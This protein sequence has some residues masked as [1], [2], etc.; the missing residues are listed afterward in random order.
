MI[1]ANRV[2]RMYFK[3][4]WRKHFRSPLSCF[5]P[6]SDYSTNTDN[7]RCEPYR[8]SVCRRHIVSSSVYMKADTTQEEIERE[9]QAALTRLGS[10]LSLTETCSKFITPSICLTA[11]PLCRETPE[12]SIHQLCRD[13]CQ[14]LETDVCAPLYDHVDSQVELDLVGVLPVCSELP[15]I[16]SQNSEMCFRLGMSNSGG[17]GNTVLL[18]CSLRRPFKPAIIFSIAA[19]RT[20]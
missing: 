7:A 18:T 19:R 2:V 1:P 16:G 14:L 5:S 8:G 9:L 17:K 11:F 15:R 12:L 3:C 10:I 4:F 20:S 13:E 6:H